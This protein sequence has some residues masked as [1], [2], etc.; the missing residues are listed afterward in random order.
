MSRSASKA[1]AIL[2]LIVG[3]AVAFVIF[4]AARADSERGVCEVRVWLN[5]A[6]LEQRVTILEEQ[7][8]SIQ[9]R[10]K[11]LE[12]ESANININ[13]AA[14]GEYLELDGPIQLSD[15]L[16]MRDGSD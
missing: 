4:L 3:I 14:P 9:A 2:V 5:I 6:L 10:L 16:W 7:V 13:S 15:E 12:P 8:E 11:A 1:P